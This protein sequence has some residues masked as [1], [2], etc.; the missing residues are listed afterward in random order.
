MTHPRKTHSLVFTFVLALS[1]FFSNFAA[2]VDQNTTYLPLKINSPAGQSELA[3][4]VDSGLENA[5]FPASFSM[6]S[7]I[8]AEKVLDYS[9]GWPPSPADL[10]KI[11][12]STGLDYVA[13]GTLTVIGEQ[14]SVDYKVFDV[15]SPAAPKYFFLH[16]ESIDNLA[17]TLSEIVRDVI[18]Y[19]ERDFIIASI[20]PAGNARID[21]GA[22]SRKVKTKAGDFY[23]PATLREDLKAIFK[24]GYFEN[25]RIEVEESENGKV[26]TFNVTEKPLIR[27][28]EYSGLDAFSKEEVAEAANIGA[29]T[30]LNNTKVNNGAAA[31]KALYKGKGYYNTTVTPQ[32][33][34]LEDGR[35]ELR[36]VIVEGDKIYIEDIK[37][38]GN[39]SFFG[40]KL[41]VYFVKFDCTRSFHCHHELIKNRFY[42]KNFFLCYT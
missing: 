16:G 38:V 9:G 17:G 11:A 14:I 28:V 33:S 35:A 41:E 7:R 29:N 2:A 25:V 4:Q 23:D 21:S 42:D 22:I 37:F 1:I 18:A 13:A 39:K 10:K 30:I 34:Y 31:V 36:Y 26:V 32:I 40:K 6:M 8:E 19:T 5:L 27:K 15:L 3:A 24:M 20:A 12:N